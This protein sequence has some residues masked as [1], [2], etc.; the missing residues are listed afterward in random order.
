VGSAGNYVNVSVYSNRLEELLGWTASGGSKHRQGVEVPQW[1]REDS[2]LCVP[3]LRGLIET[4][5]AVYSDRG[6]PMVIFSTIIP[7]LAEQVA[8]MMRGL[9]F[10][11]H[12]YKTRQCPERASFKYQVRL[13]LDVPAFLALVSPLKA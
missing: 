10:R 4:D 5:G 8:V 3:C 11:P 7:K 9:G 13:S 6:Y 12:L 2:F 1:V